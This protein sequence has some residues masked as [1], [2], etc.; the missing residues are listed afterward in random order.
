MDASTSLHRSPV[1]CRFYFHALFCCRYEYSRST[2]CTL[3]I[4]FFFWL[5]IFFVFI[6]DCS[7]LEWHDK[8]LKTFNS[9]VIFTM[10]FKFSFF[11]LFLG[12]KVFFVTLD[13]FFW[14]WKAKMSFK[15]STKWQMGGEK[16]LQDFFEQKSQDK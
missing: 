9:V 13:A 8:I 2:S 5:Y 14:N 12:M 16:S 15:R 1:F 10:N 7:Y 3:E 4:L 11:F 6:T